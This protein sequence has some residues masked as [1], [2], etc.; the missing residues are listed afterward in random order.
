[1]ADKNQF[2][3]DDD[4]FPTTDPGPRKAS[5]E[6]DFN[7]DDFAETD[8]SAAFAEGEHSA[9]IPA[10]AVKAKGGGHSRSRILLLILLLVVIVGAGAY[11]FMDLGGTTP[12]VPTVSAPAQTTA[13]SV[14]LPPQPPTTPAQPPAESATMPVTVAVPPPPPAAAA[15]GEAPPA[16]TE[17]PATQVTQ[18][19]EPMV[20]SPPAG[21]LPASQPAPRGSGPAA[22]DDPAATS[23]AETVSKAPAGQAQAQPVPAPPTAASP[24]VA[25][26][27]AKS[28]PAKP[29]PGGTYVLDAGSYLLEGN[30][31]V[32][33]AQIRKLGFEPL[34]TPVDA[35]LQMTRLRLGTFDQDEV[36]KAL[37]FAQ[38]IEPGSYSVPAGDRFVIYA[39]TFLQPESVARLSQRFLAEGIK[40]HP[41]PVQVVRTLS[42]IRFGS[43]M[44]EETAAAAAREV[45][46]A[47]LQVAVVK[48]R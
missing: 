45:G 12:S 17:M 46:L 15:A 8:L 44:T 31:D 13:K 32:L 23:A 39:G 18:P 20:A 19:A 47:G 34:I 38:S 10:P 3:F 36:V 42:R 6:P 35:T 48:S 7:D 5:P 24:P 27:V 43:Y 11:Y 16:A 33:V 37:L 29:V 21:T 2:T 22:T 26:A 41:E 4:D 40:V 28:A 14:A 1:M 30:R 9:E 25:A